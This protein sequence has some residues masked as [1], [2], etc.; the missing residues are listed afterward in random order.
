MDKFNLPSLSLNNIKPL[1]VLQ[2]VF[3]ALVS[4][5]LL[6]LSVEAKYTPPKNP[7]KPKETGTNTT[8][9]PKF[10]EESQETNIDFNSDSNFT[11]FCAPNCPPKE[12]P[13]GSNFNFVY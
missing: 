11:P 13:K 8:R 6:A 3:T 12:Q 9:S 4:L 5:N 7:S 1:Q 2:V 10:A